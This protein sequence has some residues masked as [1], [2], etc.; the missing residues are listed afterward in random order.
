MAKNQL[1]VPGKKKQFT[2]ISS[3][4]KNP[5]SLS[6]LKIFIDEAVNDKIK[7]LDRNESIKRLREEAVEKLGIQPKMFNALVSLFFNNNFDEKLAEIGE[8]ETAIDGL[9]QT[10]PVTSKDDE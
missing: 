1:V 4:I 9:M 2:E 5:S 6:Q 3:I 7:I 8:L 10:G